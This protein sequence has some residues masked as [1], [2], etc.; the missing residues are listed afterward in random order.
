MAWFLI[1]S[2][3]ISCRL[4]SPL[5]LLQIWKR[6]ENLS[7]I[8]RYQYEE[9]LSWKQNSLNLPE[10]IASSRI[11][12]N[13]CESSLESE[14]SIEQNNLQREYQI[15]NWNPL[16]KMPDCSSKCFITCSYYPCTSC[17]DQSNHFSQS[18]IPYSL[19]QT[20]QYPLQWPNSVNYNYKATQIEKV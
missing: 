16:Q 12:L 7:N 3:P 10:A 6:K 17:R 15:Q 20:P 8:S 13:R 14:Q 2:L 9:S 11:S 4:F 18:Q 5:A 19:L 1:F